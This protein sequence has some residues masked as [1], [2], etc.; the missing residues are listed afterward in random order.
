MVPFH[1]VQLAVP[2][3]LPKDFGCLV[4]SSSRLIRTA[5]DSGLLVTDT[6]CLAHHTSGT[7]HRTSDTACS[8]HLALDFCL[9][10]EMAYLTPA[11][12]ASSH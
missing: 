8:A 9:S 3:H 6:A 12:L 2:A 11:W 7:S 1:H 10:M 4:K 5:A